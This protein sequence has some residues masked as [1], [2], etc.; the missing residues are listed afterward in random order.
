M[1]VYPLRYTKAE[2]QAAPEDERLLFLLACQVANDI[3]MLTKQTLFA[4]NYEDGVPQPVMHGQ[5]ALVTLNMKLLASR[6]YE[7]WNELNGVHGKTFRAYQ[8][9]FDDETKA[10]LK[11]LGREFADN[12]HSQLRNKVG[13][14]ID[15][16]ALR[17]G[18]DAIPANEEL[19]DYSSETRANSLYYATELA[20][21]MAMAG[22]TGLPWKEGLEVLMNRVTDASGRLND[23]LQ[24]IIMVFAIRHLKVTQQQILDARIELKAPRMP[25]VTVPYFTEP[26]SEEELAAMKGGVA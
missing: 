18:Y 12:F 24:Q 20:S 3:G 23:V 4:R 14:H 7:G 2:L 25:D 5:I 8:D 17:A 15:L 19:V 1:N 26:P 11:S 9:Q 22:F 21:V 13:S 6:T 16:E 10:S